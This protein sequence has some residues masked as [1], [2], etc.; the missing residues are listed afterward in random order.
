MISAIKR[1]EK[2]L[3]CEGKTLEK[4]DY[5]NKEIINEQNKQ[6]DINALKRKINVVNTQEFVKCQIREKVRIVSC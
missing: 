1:Y 3:E 4:L 5:K 2:S 6:L